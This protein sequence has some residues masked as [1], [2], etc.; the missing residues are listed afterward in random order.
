MNNKAR[1]P[2]NRKRLVKVIPNSERTSNHHF[3]TK[4]QSQR[5]KELLKAQKIHPQKI[6]P[7]S[8]RPTNCDEGPQINKNNHQ[9]QLIKRLKDRMPK[10]VLKIAGAIKEKI[11]NML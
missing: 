6:H 9:K 1:G 5:L 7:L 8:N 11:Y 3:V 4:I 2:D 10:S